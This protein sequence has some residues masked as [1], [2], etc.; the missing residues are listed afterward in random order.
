MSTMRCLVC[1][2]AVATWAVG[3]ADEVSQ[4]FYLRHMEF[5]RL[6]VAVQ[7]GQAASDGQTLVARYTED[8]ATDALLF[9]EDPQTRNVITVVG[10]LCTT[11]DGR[12]ILHLLTSV[13]HF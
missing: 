10:G 4:T 5:R 8:P 3:R 13:L 2:L 11:D 7:D 1:V 9:K 12:G 6:V